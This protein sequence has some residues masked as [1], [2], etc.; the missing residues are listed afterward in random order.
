MKN[1]S[2]QK[3]LTVIGL[4]SGTS[5]DG[6]DAV[7]VKT[8]GIKIDRSKKNYSFSY[9]KSTKSL[10]QEA[11]QNPLSFLKNKKRSDLLSYKVTN[12]HI[13]CIEKIINLYN[14]K[15]DLIGFH[16]QTI[17]HNPKEKS[18]IQIGDPS[19][20]SKK[21]GI[22]VIS[23]FRLIDLKSGGQ[24]APLAPIY[25]K[26]LIHNLKLALPSCFLNIGGISNITYLDESYL[27]GFDIGPG[28]VLIDK[29]MQKNQKM[30]FDY[31]G[32]LASTGKIIKSF[33]KKF[34][35]DP[36]FSMKY[37]KSLDKNYFLENYHLINQC[38]YKIEDK[39]CTLTEMTVESLINGL[40][41][42]PII[43]KNIVICGGGAKNSYL[44][45]RLKEKLEQKKISIFIADELG[46]N[47]Q[48][49]EA[50]LFAFLAARS[51]FKLPITFPN[52][53]GIKKKLSGGVLYK[54]PSESL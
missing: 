1:Y 18:S 7:I 26:Y 15:V 34:N 25:H 29:F 37:P 39:V 31:N 27:I 49:I 43:P 4:M 22:D 20:M 47:S 54:K 17:Y 32:E 14:P 12:D 21:T 16:G 53:T 41:H 3:L 35:K 8:N 5:M 2:K 11:E 10:L 45:K 42:L 44:V 40:K 19:L 52:T 9:C 6:I 38:K 46:L 24:G 13:K 50:E 23:D 51:L 33:L 36:Y 30:K 28:N 48:M